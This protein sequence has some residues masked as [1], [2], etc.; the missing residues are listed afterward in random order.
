MIN[1]PSRCDYEAFAIMVFNSMKL[2]SMWKSKVIV[3]IEIMD[4]S[5]IK[6][7]HFLFLHTR[8]I[9][10]IWIRL[11][12]YLLTPG[13]QEGNSQKKGRKLHCRAMRKTWKFLH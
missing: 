5:C 6:L 11:S 8:G 10:Q 9:N 4:F 12:E 1:L 7:G 2:A 13:S 3:R